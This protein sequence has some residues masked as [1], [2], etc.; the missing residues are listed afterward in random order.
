MLFVPKK[1]PYSTH[2]LCGTQL[3][4]FV[5]NSASQER[6]GLV[7]TSLGA[8]FQTRLS[9][10]WWTSCSLC[11]HEEEREREA[12][13][14]F[15]PCCLWYIM[16]SVP[17]NFNESSFSA[18]SASSFLS[19]KASHLMMLN[20]FSIFQHL[21]RGLVVWI[22]LCKPATAVVYFSQRNWLA[23]L[24]CVFSA[25]VHDVMHGIKTLRAALSDILYWFSV[26]CSCA[27][28][29]CERRT[30]W[31]HLAASVVLFCQH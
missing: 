15:R 16:L 1:I 8:D 25:P 21:I 13:S 12:G 27:C 18:Y 23:M 9:F 7:S 3:T 22:V 2:C 11:H 20:L 29:V 31:T 10:F 5:G 24:W 4:F 28:V 30:F 6:V 14:Y 17:W 19:L 26:W